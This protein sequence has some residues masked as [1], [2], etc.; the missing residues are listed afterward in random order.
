MVL[1]RGFFSLSES[2]L[3]YLTVNETQQGI[4][5]KGSRIELFNVESSNSKGTG[6]SIDI[7]RTT[8]PLKYSALILTGNSENGV[9][10][11]ENTHVSNQLDF[12]VTG[13]QE[14]ILVLADCVVNNNTLNGI[15]IESNANVELQNCSVSNNIKAGIKLQ[16][17]ND[18]YML[19]NSSVISN[20]SEYAIH[21]FISNGVSVLSSI[22]KDHKYGYYTYWG[23]W[24]T[25]PFV[26][27]NKQTYSGNTSIIIKDSNFINNIA[28]GLQIISDYSSR[29]KTH[30]VIEANHFTGGNKT[31]YITDYSSWATS[32]LTVEMSDNIVEKNFHI[33]SENEKLLDFYLGNNVKLDITKNSFRNNTASTGIYV[34][35]RTSSPK[36]ITIQDN[37]FLGNNFSSLV[38]NI[39][40][41]LFIKFFRN[42]FDRVFMTTSGCILGLPTFDLSYAINASHNYWGTSDFKDVVESVCGFEID[43]EKAFVWYLPYYTDMS[44]LTLSD[45]RSQNFNI[46]GVL[47]GDIAEDLTIQKPTFIADLRI[48][49]SILI[50]YI[51]S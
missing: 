39:P 20:N 10:I 46:S 51:I 44:L 37:Q 43:F 40:E 5:I 33:A 50:R 21:G 49:R 16:Q 45:E 15:Y 17:A 34:S 31:F 48:D 1:M 7:S 32:T 9:Y 27:L 28:D 14:S 24:D 2:R 26:Y 13:V 47:G 36:N 25:R 42:V 12:G 30:L 19:I 41:R 11:H 38:I 18:G 23:R 29:G 35:Q 4:T 8:S 6:L 3:H 22:V